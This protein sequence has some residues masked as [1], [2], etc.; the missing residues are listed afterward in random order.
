M[1]IRGETL[2]EGM[3]SALMEL[4]TRAWGETWGGGRGREAGVGGGLEGQK[5]LHI[6]N[7]LGAARALAVKG[8]PGRLAGE[9]VT[10]V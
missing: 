4:Q 7:Y 5:D 2:S 8:E 10:G 3:L 6:W 1:L 9:R